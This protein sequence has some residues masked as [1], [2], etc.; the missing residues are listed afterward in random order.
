MGDKTGKH[1]S[2]YPKDGHMPEL[3]VSGHKHRGEG[4]HSFVSVPFSVP[5]NAHFISHCSVRRQ[6]TNSFPSQKQ[7]SIKND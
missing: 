1:P 3:D 2:E 4:R 6:N 7:R 5:L